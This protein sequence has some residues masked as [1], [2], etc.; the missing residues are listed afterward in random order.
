M[1]WYSCQT[2]W[3]TS[4]VSQDFLTNWSLSLSGLAVPLAWIHAS[5][6]HHPEDSSWEKHKPSKN[7]LLLQGGI[8]MTCAFKYIRIVGLAPHCSA[9]LGQNSCGKG[10]QRKASE[11][12][13]GFHVAISGTP[14]ACNLSKI[15][16]RMILS[17]RQKHSN[18]TPKK[19]ADHLTSV[20]AR[21][22]FALALPPP[23]RRLWS[24][25]L[26]ATFHHR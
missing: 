5:T 12:H 23:W 6:A 17:W 21:T 10:L 1:T 4:T 18:S 24:A 22:S 8:R 26:Q 13:L 16:C 14:S 19:N 15:N 20:C 9:L 2:P 7:C 3:K 25:Q 11:I